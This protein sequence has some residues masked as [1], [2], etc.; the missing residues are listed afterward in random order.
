MCNI[1]DDKL[2]IDQSTRTLP[3]IENWWEQGKETTLH[4]YDVWIIVDFEQYWLLNGVTYSKVNYLNA[5]IIWSLAKRLFAID[6]PNRLL[7]VYMLHYRIFRKFHYNFIFR[8]MSCSKNIKIKH[9]VSLINFRKAKDI[10]NI[11]LIE[12]ILSEIL[13]YKNFQKCDV[14]FIVLINYALCCLILMIINA[15]DIV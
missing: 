6:L 1:A 4:V 7:L 11:C 9:Y 12:M 5:P 8:R 3:T 14:L 2:F 15:E 10:T 13:L